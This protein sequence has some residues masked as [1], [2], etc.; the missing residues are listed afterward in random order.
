M[1]N[2]NVLQH[3]TIDW[4][5]WDQ[6]G[7]LYYGSQ[8]IEIDGVTRSSVGYLIEANPDVTIYDVFPDNVILDIPILASSDVQTDASLLPPWKQ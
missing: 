3:T 2:D 5:R 8:T 1:T 4:E 6:I 7:Q